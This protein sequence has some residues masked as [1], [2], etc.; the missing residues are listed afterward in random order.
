MF[1][2]SE[3]ALDVSMN[4]SL[5]SLIDS[6]ETEDQY[7]LDRA[8]PGRRRRPDGARHRWWPRRGTPAVA[9]LIVEAVGGH[10]RA[11]VA[12]QRDGR[13]RDAAR[14][15]ESRSAIVAGLE[16]GLAGRR[17]ARKPEA[18]EGFRDSLAFDDI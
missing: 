3:I 9:G 14:T 17:R 10:R 1:G 7:H 18:W 16:V 6:C 13:G 15:R 12:G 4:T 8:D 11:P 5:L 2:I